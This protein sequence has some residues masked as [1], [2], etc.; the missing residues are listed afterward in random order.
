[1]Y[2]AALLTAPEALPMGSLLRDWLSRV[3]VVCAVVLS[4]AP[5][6]ASVAWLM[7]GHATI[8]QVVQHESALEHGHA[9]HHG[10]YAAGDVHAP[11]PGAPAQHG[12]EEPDA[13]GLSLELSPAAASASLY[14]DAFQGG[15]VE[16]PDIRTTAEAWRL[17]SS[18]EISLRQHFPPILHRPPV[19]S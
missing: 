2:A 11:Q 3:A 1:M 9:D 17:R 18:A 8:E 19:V 5:P 6:A 12:S 15:L 4:L 13:V 7:G 10:S 16:P 14:H